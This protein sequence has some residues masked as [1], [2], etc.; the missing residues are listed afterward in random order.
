MY[1]HHHNGNNQG[2]KVYEDLHR[3]TGVLPALF[4]CFFRTVQNRLLK[5][6]KCIHKNYNE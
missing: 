3:V 1:G 6:G 4:V 5:T 2:E